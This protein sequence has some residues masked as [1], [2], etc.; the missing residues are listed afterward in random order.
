MERRVQGSPA[1]PIGPCH[2]PLPEKLITTGPT[3]ADFTH[4]PKH[5]P[6]SASWNPDSGTLLGDINKCLGRWVIQ[7]NK[8]RRIRVFTTSLF[9]TRRADETFQRR[10]SAPM[11]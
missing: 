10:V 6:Y 8:T 11:S 5:L 4:T 9:R 7:E 2:K 3:H 1:A